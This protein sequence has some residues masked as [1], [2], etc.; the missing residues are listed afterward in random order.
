VVRAIQR[1]LTAFRR[2]HA[3]PVLGII[4]PWLDHR[5]AGSARRADRRRPRSARSAA[6]SSPTAFVGPITSSVK[7]RG[8]A[9][10]RYFLCMKGRHPRPTC[11]GYARAVAS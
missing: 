11:K 4:I 3:S 5:A 6:C 7:A 8:D 10:T 2:S 1:S 9:S